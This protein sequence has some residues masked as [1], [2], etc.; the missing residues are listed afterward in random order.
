[1]S[2]AGQIGG[3]E[4]RRELGRGGMGV[5]YLAHDPR[6]DRHVAIKALPDASSLDRDRLGMLR[7]EARLVAQLNHPHIAQIHHL[8]EEDGRI[9]LVLEYVEGRTLRETLPGMAADEA[10]R[11]GAQI[12]DA[13][14]AAHRRGVVHRDLKPGNVMIGEG[15][16][17][18]ILDFGLAIAATGE[19]ASPG[20]SSASAAHPTAGTPGYMSPE[21]W[22]GEPIDARADVFA[23]GC[24]LY[25]MLTGEQAVRGATVAD[26]AAATITVADDL[27][28]LPAGAPA[29]LRDVLRRCLAPDVADRYASMSD[30][31]DALSIATGSTPVRRGSVGGPM[32]PNNLPAIADRFVGR[33]EELR[34]LS[35]LVGVRRL[36]TLTG[37]GGCG[38]S[39]LAVEAARRVLARF[40][41]GA[42]LVQLASVDR[43]TLVAGAVGAALGVKD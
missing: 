29:P 32:P 37:A 11:V 16:A 30:V 9:Y 42:W 31:L 43:G 26:L 7:Q 13:L 21:Q 39:R 36:V 40:E 8:L 12:A 5:V 38:K 41:A 25:E 6:L 3:F 22:R 20:S 1:M 24:V 14:A 15:G 28:E 17:A 2:G 34:S 23:Y 27:D 10:L 35:S 33:L 4:L 18:K 19:G